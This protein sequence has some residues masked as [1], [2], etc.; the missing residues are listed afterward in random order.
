[1]RKLLRAL[2]P[3]L[4]AP[5]LAAP[6][7]SCSRLHGTSSV[8][9]ALLSC[10]MLP[11]PCARACLLAAPSWMP[12]LPL[13]L[14]LEGLA[15]RGAWRWNDSIPAPAPPAAVGSSPVSARCW[16]AVS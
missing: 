13:L 12:L 2:P 7:A 5:E 1:V 9:C 14:L 10:P 6:R 15:R 11:A 4:A 8:N 16:P 3:P